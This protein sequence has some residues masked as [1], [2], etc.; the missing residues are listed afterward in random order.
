MLNLVHLNAEYTL[1]PSTNLA[2]LLTPNFLG[3]ANAIVDLQLCGLGPGSLGGVV[4]I[5]IE[6]YAFVFRNHP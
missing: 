2:L 5:C 1:M 6:E 4:Q 3:G